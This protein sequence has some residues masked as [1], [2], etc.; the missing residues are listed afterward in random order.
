MSGDASASTAPTLEQD[1]FF[2]V[3]CEGKAPITATHAEDPLMARAVSALPP[4]V[5]EDSACNT[6]SVRQ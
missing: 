1:R 5:S 3:G 2:P 6:R 4:P